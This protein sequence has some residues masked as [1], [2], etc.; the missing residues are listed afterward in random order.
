MG[1]PVSHTPLSRSAPPTPAGGTAKR[2]RPLIVE[3][4]GPAG[5]GKTALLRTLGRDPRVHAGVRIDRVRQFGEMLGHGI[6]VLPIALAL[7]NQGWKRLWYGLLHFVRLRTLPRAITLA[8]AGAEADAILL[9]EGPVFSLARL[10][11]FQQANQG[12]G[13]LADAWHA[14]LDRWSGLL[15]LV[16]WTDAPDAVLAERIRS[17]LKRHQIKGGS[18]AEV[19]VFLERY[20]QAYREILASLTTGKRVGMVHLDTT[21]LAVDVAAGRLL[22]ELE[23]LGLRR[24]A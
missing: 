3:I 6:A 20:R 16:I 2:T 24:N 21:G 18:D 12:A 23:Q 14:E 5:A 9:D 4:V 8:A 11:V 17:R 1:L 10:S 15:D 19:A 13:R 22:A 7:L